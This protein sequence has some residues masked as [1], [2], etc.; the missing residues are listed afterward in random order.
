MCERAKDD[1][2]FSQAVK[3]HQ[4]KAEAAEKA[5]D[6][7]QAGQKG[8]EE[9]AREAVAGAAALEWSVRKAL[10]DCDAA[11]ANEDQEAG[12]VQVAEALSVL[13]EML[14]PDPEVEQPGEAETG[15]EE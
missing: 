14:G 4:T 7:A 6:E 3:V 12:R 5:R 2:G 11:M 9:A 10:N 1:P 13:R 8:A 15:A